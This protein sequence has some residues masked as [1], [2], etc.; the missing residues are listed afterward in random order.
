MRTSRTDQTLGQSISFPSL[1]RKQ[2]KGQTAIQGYIVFYWKLFRW[3]I[4]YSEPKQSCRCFFVM[5]TSTS[6]YL[7][8]KCVKRKLFLWKCS[9]GK[10][11]VKNNKRVT[12]FCKIR[13]KKS[14]HWELTGSKKLLLIFLLISG[15]VKLV[16]TIFWTWE[17][18]IEISLM[19]LGRG[20]GIWWSCLSLQS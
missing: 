12:F 3:Q 17:I 13:V 5:T 8:V 11:R 4:N 1:L 15:S 6:C 7:H 16:I 2:L 9:C 10:M 18:Y 19:P 14:C 20:G